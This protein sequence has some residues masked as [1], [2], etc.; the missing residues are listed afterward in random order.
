M[1]LTSYRCQGNSFAERASVAAVAT[2]LC[3]LFSVLTKPLLLL[4]ELRPIRNQTATHV[5]ERSRQLTLELFAR[6][7][8]L[9]II[10]A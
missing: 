9:L 2:P 4:M 10:D 6:I 8:H 5:A 7:R 1:Y 3:D